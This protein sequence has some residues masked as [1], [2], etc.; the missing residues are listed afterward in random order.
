MVCPDLAVRRAAGGEGYEVLGDYC[1]GCGLCVR[2]CPTG[3]M[4][5]VEERR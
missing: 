3:S 2:E 4:Q 1:K 5:L